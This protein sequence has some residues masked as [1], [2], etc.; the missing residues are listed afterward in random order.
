MITADAGYHSDANI[1]QLR[2]NNIPALIA[3]NQM[4]SRDERFAEQD[5]YKG[6]PDPLSEKKATG[7]AKEI[8]RFQP[9]DFAFNDDNTATRPA[10]MRSR[11]SASNRGVSEAQQADQREKSGTLRR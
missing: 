5:K 10:G 6:K 4:R 8:K 7:Q 3:D 1:K 9:Q 11:K 2:D